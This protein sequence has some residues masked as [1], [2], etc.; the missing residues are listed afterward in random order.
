MLLKFHKRKNCF[1]LLK[2]LGTI[3]G[4]TFSVQSPLPCPFQKRPSSFLQ[5]GQVET[6]LDPY[7]HR[8]SRKRMMNTLLVISLPALLILCKFPAFLNVG[9]RLYIISPNLQRD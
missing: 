4:L 7:P 3:W 9:V 8:Q 2:K 5:F 6:I 1:S